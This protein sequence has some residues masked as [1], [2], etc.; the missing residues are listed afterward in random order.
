MNKIITIIVIA[1]IMTS[2]SPKII[3]N[4]YVF[5]NNN[6]IGTDSNQSP[7]KTVGTSFGAS[8]SATAAASNSGP[9]ENSGSSEAS[10]IPTVPITV[11]TETLK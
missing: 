2:C 1:I 5:G 4:N 3:N 7:E 6:K 8:I 10:S 11:P 9:A